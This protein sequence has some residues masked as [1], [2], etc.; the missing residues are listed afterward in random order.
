M[1]RRRTLIITPRA[2]ESLGKGKTLVRLSMS[3]RKIK[4]KRQIDCFKVLQLM[5]VSKHNMLVI[6][7]Y[8]H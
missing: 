6:M 8:A 2:G 4:I 5:K 7:P 3:L 1:S